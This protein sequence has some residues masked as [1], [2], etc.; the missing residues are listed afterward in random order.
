[1]C[2]AY[3][4][5]FNSLNLTNGSISFYSGSNTD[6]IPVAILLLKKLQQG[7][8]TLMI[9]DNFGNISPADKLSLELKIRAL[10]TRWA[11]LDQNWQENAEKYALL[12]KDRICHFQETTYDCRDIKIHVPMPVTG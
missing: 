11:T 9:L 3:Q 6:G 2:F 7:I 5:A 1:M 12:I 10:A 4:I 8:F